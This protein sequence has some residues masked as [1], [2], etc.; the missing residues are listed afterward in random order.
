MKKFLLKFGLFYA[1][2]LGTV[3]VIE[4]ILLIQPNIYSYKRSYIER[5]LDNI[6]ILIMGHSHFEEGIAPYIIRNDDSLFNFAIAGQVMLYTDKL[7]QKY[8]PQMNHLETVIL[9]FRYGDG[10]VF[11]KR[12]NEP[13]RK[14]NSQRC[15][16]Y[17]YMHISVNQT[18][19][20][21]YWSELM[22][23]KMNFWK[24]L[25]ADKD[26]CAVGWGISLSLTELDSLKGFVPLNPDNRK[27]GWQKVNLPVEIDYSVRETSYRNSLESIA[28]LCQ[29]KGVRLVLIT[30]PW[31]KESQQLLTEY[32]INE[33]RVFTDSLIN[34]YPVV[35]YYNYLFD[36]RFIDDDFYDATHLNR[37][38]AEKFSNILK[39][40]IKGLSQ[41]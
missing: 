26:K 12:I 1:L 27:E 41:E 22:N 6:K 31:N 21:L 28:K 4:L 2:F 32:G 30:C 11:K 29:D 34:K 24:R 5:N 14:D 15:M 17:K 3:V 39:K 18:T 40:E 36:G 37:N 16:Y 10:Y 38:G 20:W 9:P 19:D 25:T 7:V 23:S 33:M 8:I 35:E 13:K